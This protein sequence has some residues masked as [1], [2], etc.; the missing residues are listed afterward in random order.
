MRSQIGKAH[1]ALLRTLNARRLF[2]HNQE[3]VASFCFDD[4]PRTAYSVGGGIL[5]AFGA[6]GTYYAALG[7]MNT[8]DE[9][10]DLFRREDLFSLLADGHEL[11]SHTFSHLSCRRVASTTF[12][13]DVQKGRDAI[14]E[15]TGVDPTDFAY[16]FG[17]LT[18]SAKRRIGM[19]MAS[20]RGTYGGINGP[21]LDLNLLNANNVYGGVD[22][23]AE[24][25]RLLREN[26]AERRWLIFYTHDVRENPSRFGCTPALL[27]KTVSSALQ[28]GYRIVPV[29]ETIRTE[30]MSDLPGAGY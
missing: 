4:F 19:R 2:L 11:A 28:H 7:L 15:M 26:A 25:E 24:M 8:Q 17:H 14:H 5:K 10:G 3:P 13:R 29:G 1:Q 9:L 23:L 16:P 27:E 18:V 30:M 22:Q 20:C 12:E 6:R 21:G